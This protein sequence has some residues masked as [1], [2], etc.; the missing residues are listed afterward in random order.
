MLAMIPTYIYRWIFFGVNVTAFTNPAL[1]DLANQKFLDTSEIMFYFLMLVSYIAMIIISHK[2]GKDIG[3]S[4]LIAF[5]IVAAIFDLILS[6]V[7]FVPTIFNILTIVLGLIASTTKVDF[8][9]SSSMTDSTKN[10]AEPQIKSVNPASVLTINTEP[11]KRLLNPKPQEFDGDRILT[12]DA[13]KIF[14]SKKYNIKKNDLFNKF[15]VN[16]TK[17]FDT[18]D[19]ALLYALN[20]EKV[21]IETS[22][23]IE[24]GSDDWVENVADIQNEEFK[25]KMLSHNIQ[26]TLNGFLY[27]NITFK[28]LNLA[29]EYAEKNEAA[30]EIEYKQIKNAKQKSIILFSIIV[31]IVSIIWYDSQTKEV[32]DE[33]TNNQPNSNPY[34]IDKCNDCGY[35]VAIFVKTGSLNEIDGATSKIL[36]SKILESLPKKNRYLGKFQAYDKKWRILVGRFNN[37]NEAETFVTKLKSYGTH[38]YVSVDGG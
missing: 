27:K 37:P 32:K 34:T 21:L 36:Q 1:R 6:F 23:K 12:N 19:D 33:I 9:T 26:K 16:N 15:E 30:E 7:P 5:P 35:S 38:V 22:T 8:D 25:K 20:E 11:Q 14:L 18:L 28:S 10:N 24:I 2:R 31:L 4:F 17:L 3:K 29:I 13:Y